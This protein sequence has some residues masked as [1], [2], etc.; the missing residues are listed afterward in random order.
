MTHT[1]S[2][3]PG[4]TT[5][6]EITETTTSNDSS[7]VKTTIGKKNIYIGN[8]EQV[9]E[10]AVASKVIQEAI[11]TEATSNIAAVEAL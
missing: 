6:V 10:T 3:V 4:D 8:Q 9:K 2:A 1:F 11:A 7:V 5:L